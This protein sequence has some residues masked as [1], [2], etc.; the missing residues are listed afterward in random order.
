VGGALALGVL[1]I[2]LGASGLDAELGLRA[3]SRATTLAPTGTPTLTRESFSVWPRAALVLDVPGARATAEYAPRLW[4]SDVGRSPDPLVDQNVAARLESRVTGPWRAEASAAAT[5]GRTDPLADLSTLAAAAATGQQVSTTPI[6]Y[7]SLRTVGRGEVQLD[8]RNTVAAGGSF[9]VSGGT[10]PAARALYPTQR[11]ETADLSLTH[12]ATERTT[13]RVRADGGWTVTS[14][15]GGDVTGGYATL[16]GSCGWRA[17]PRLTGW[18]GAGASFG[19]DDG[20]TTAATR[21]VRPA[22]Q[23]GLIRD[24]AGGPVA[25]D[26]TLRLAPAVDRFSGAVRTLADGTGTLRWQV[27]PSVAVTTSASAGVFTDG[28]TMLAGLDVRSAW[29]LR[30]RV[31]LTAGVLGRWQREQRP[32]FPSFREAG[33][34]AGMEYRPEARP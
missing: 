6:P 15:S 10:T 3:E 29:Q 23:L 17:T 32:A 25:L 18:V 34:I 16:S 9:A 5:R 33:V 22:G 1:A 8:P 21:R 2:T 11:T 31:A 30:P 12:L 20:P 28:D 26:L 7:Q 13:L 27:S 4:T 19:Y 14:G 24:A